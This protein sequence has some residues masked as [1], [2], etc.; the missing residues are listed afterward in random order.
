MNS[1]IVNTF[2]CRHAIRL[3]LWI[4]FL[5]G[6]RENHTLPLQVWQT[7]PALHLVNGYWYHN[8][9]LLTGEINQQYPDGSIKSIER[10]AGG[11]QEGISETYYETGKRE[12]LR[13]YHLGEKDSIHTGW[14]PNGNKKFEYHFNAGNYDGMFTEW[15]ESG[16]LFQQ[17]LYAMGKEVQG[18]GWRENGKIYLN[19]QMRNGR[20]F[21]LNNANLCYALQDGQVVK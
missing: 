4:T 18:K 10:Y 15:Y 20:R 21:G 3:I 9:R 1:R 13:T 19:F 11:K 8:D 5:A 16:N 2:G 7:D 14:W 12:S 17:I 6:C